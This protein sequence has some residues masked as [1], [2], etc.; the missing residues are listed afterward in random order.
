MWS[1][2]SAKGPNH[3]CAVGIAPV[4]TSSIDV[5]ICTAW[6]ALAFIASGAHLRAWAGWNDQLVA[7]SIVARHLVSIIFPMRPSLCLLFCAVCTFVPMLT[8]G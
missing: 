3:E 1:S 5:E 8:Y 2:A 7:L 6:G 4:N